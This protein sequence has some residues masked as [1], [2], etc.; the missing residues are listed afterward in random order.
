MFSTDYLHNLFLGP[1]VRSRLENVPKH[2]HL[3]YPTPLLQSV[4]ALA[5]VGTGHSFV[6]YHRTVST[7][8]TR[9]A[10]HLEVVVE[11]VVIEAEEGMLVDVEQ[12]SLMM[13]VFID[14]DALLSVLAL[15]GLD[16]TQLST[17]DLA[18]PASPAHRRRY[19]PC[20]SA[21]PFAARTRLFSCWP[22]DGAYPL[23]VDAAL[24]ALELLELLM[25]LLV[26]PLAC[27]QNSCRGVNTFHAA[28]HHRHRA[29]SSGS[30]RACPCA[31]SRRTSSP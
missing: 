12:V 8:S 5:A 26:L 6:A 3:K 9:R 23:D 24:A 18:L 20:L 13:V 14:L 17:S 29:G 4:A 21:I 1:W 7:K 25:R 11:V 2:G 31:G 22:V 15:V 16:N 19:A 10:V 28:L 30:F 27:S